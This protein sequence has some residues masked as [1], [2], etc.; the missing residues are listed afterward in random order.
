MYS[1]LVF[2]AFYELFADQNTVLAWDCEQMEMLGTIEIMKKNNQKNVFKNMK[3]HYI[4]KQQMTLQEK[5]PSK[6]DYEKHFS[7][8]ILFPFSPPSELGRLYPRWT[9]YLTY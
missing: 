7:K 1:A 6:C 2:K 4:T 3:I 9:K 5:S 8:E